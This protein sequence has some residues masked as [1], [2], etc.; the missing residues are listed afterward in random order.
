M[1]KKAAGSSTLS[2]DV[3]RDLS[4]VSTQTKMLIPWKQ[5]WKY[6]NSS[7]V[8]TGHLHHHPP[9]QQK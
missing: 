9:T 4:N 7:Y 3:T 6:P 2:S 8:P 1:W 5:T